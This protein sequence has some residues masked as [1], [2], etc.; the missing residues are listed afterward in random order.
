MPEPR[1]VGARLAHG[2]GRKVHPDHLAHFGASSSSVSPMPQPRLKT[3]DCRP[4]PGQPEDPLAPCGGAGRA[5]PGGRNELAQSPSK[6]SRGIPVRARRRPSGGFPLAQE[7]PWRSNSSEPASRL[8]SRS[9]VFHE[10]MSSV[11]PKQPQLISIPMRS[12]RTIRPKNISSSR[13]AAVADNAQ[14]PARHQQDPDRQFQPRQG[15]GYDF[16]GLQR[17]KLV[18]ADGQRKQLPRV[19]QFDVSGVNENYAQNDAKGN[20]GPV[21]LLI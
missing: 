12:A 10:I 19:P 9:S 13:D 21:D 3:R 1:G 14:P 18:R 16:D 8:P 15:S 5:R 17:Q 7:C 6:A 11:P 20:G 4:A 2:G